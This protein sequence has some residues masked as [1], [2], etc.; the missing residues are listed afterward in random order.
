M[1][2]EQ[3]ESQISGVASHFQVLK[4]SKHKVYG[5][6][7]QR[8]AFCCQFCA[9]DLEPYNRSCLKRV[10]SSATNKWTVDSTPGCV[11][12]VMGR[13]LLGMLER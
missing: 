3:C 7:A 4:L 6:R 1:G 11:G 9:R 8:E 5:R 2:V 10:A 13:P 12:E